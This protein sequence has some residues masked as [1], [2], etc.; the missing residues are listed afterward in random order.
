MNSNEPKTKSLK[1]PYQTPELRVYGDVK[2]IVQS[3]GASPGGHID[4]RSPYSTDRTH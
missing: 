3:F 1:K 2:D 4:T